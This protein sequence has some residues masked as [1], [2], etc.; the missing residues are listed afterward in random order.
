VLTLE[1]NALREGD[2][3]VVHDQDKKERAPKRGVV[4]LIDTE[5][6]IHGVGIRTANANGTNV[7]VWPSYL[8]VHRDPRDQAEPCWRC[9]ALAEAR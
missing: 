8:A 1:W 3:V 5:S 4:A 7:I 6:H 2:K 9:Q